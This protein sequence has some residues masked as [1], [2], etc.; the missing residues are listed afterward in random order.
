MDDQ[1]LGEALDDL[2]S[3]PPERFVAARNALGRNLR[4]SGRKQEAATVTGWRRPTRTAWALNRLARVEHEVVVA[5][6]EAAIGLRDEQATGGAGLREAMADLRRATRRATDA[7]VA[8][9]TPTRPSDHADVT[10][11]LL[12]V[13]SDTEALKSLAAGRLLE[14]P[15][16]GLGAFESAPAG[17]TDLRSGPKPQARRRRGGE[18]RDDDAAGREA[19]REAL[20]A[21]HQERKA[22]KALHERAAADVDEAV[23]AM[24]RAIAQLERSRSELAGAEAGVE[25]AEVAKHHAL[26]AAAA[27]DKSLADAESAVAELE[28]PP[29]D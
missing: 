15:E 29:A 24:E 11:A 2:F 23:R 1:E 12:A 5:L 16:A 4:S 28:Q 21:A 20:Q 10:A 3:Q 17:P 25:A 27:A 26:S 7:A 22:A 18:Q 9:I 8:G 13:L 19:L 6:V 14:I